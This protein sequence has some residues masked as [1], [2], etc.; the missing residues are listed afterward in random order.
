MT[1]S[2]QT[3][4]LVLSFGQELA[5]PGRALLVL[6]RHDVRVQRLRLDAVTWDDGSRFRML[7]EATFADEHQFLRVKAS[8]SRLC[9]LIQLVEPA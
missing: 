7:V 2:T 8:L 1:V 9:G 4:S 5:D 3:R 6:V